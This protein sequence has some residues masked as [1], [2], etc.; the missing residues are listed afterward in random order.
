M[1]IS[2]SM[3]CFWKK[4][5]SHTHILT[6]SYGV[7]MSLLPSCFSVLK[8][9]IQRLNY[10]VFLVKTSESFQIWTKS[11]ENK[12]EGNLVPLG[13]EYSIVPCRK[14]HRI[15]FHIVWYGVTMFK[16]QQHKPYKRKKHTICSFQKVHKH[17]LIQNKLWSTSHL[18]KYQII[19]VS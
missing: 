3:T 2:C 14:S 5:Q 16:T 10:R 4:F 13:E 17:S 11:V 9:Y 6:I 18:K 1:R 15:V 8:M 7:N 12:W 19:L